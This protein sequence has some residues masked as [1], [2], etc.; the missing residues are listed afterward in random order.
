[1]ELGKPDAS[2]R[3]SPLPIEGSEYT[4]EVD[5]IIA[6]IGQNIDSS[7]LLDLEVTSWGSIV[8]DEQTGQTK[9]KNVFAGGDCVTGA[10]IAVNAVAAG[11]RAA[12]SIKQFLQGEPVVGDPKMYNHSMGKLDEVPPAVFEQF[13][14]QE[15]TAMPRLAP[16]QRA[17]GFDEVEV[18]FTPEQ[19]RSEA[20]RCMECGCRDAHECALRDFAT[21]FG[22]SAERFTGDKR[23]YRRD[24]SH[25]VLVYEEHKCIQCGC[26]VRACDELLKS[27]CLGFAGRGFEARVKPA[28]DRRL[29]LI[30]DEELPKV[31]EYCP[32]GAL[33]LKTDAVATLKPGA[34]L[35]SKG[36]L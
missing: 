33:T 6:A 11:R 22:A 5:E 28:L 16:K 26:C 3:R 29:A 32:V 17:G 10:D 25:A 9:M 13:N 14:P 8:A 12:F 20:A 21:R 23:T 27:P 24:D 1:M 35:T 30:N 7:M 18:G 34:F 19:A 2:G 36:E 15:R 4:I 31:A